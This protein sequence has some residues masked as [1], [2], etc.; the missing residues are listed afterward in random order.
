MSESISDL[1]AKRAEVVDKWNALL[2]DEQGNVKDVSENEESEANQYEKQVQELD[3]KIA[4]AEKAQQAKAAAAQ[5]VTSPGTVPA[6]AIQHDQ[7]KGQK[8]ARA[9]RCIARGALERRSAEDVA[10]EIYGDNAYPINRAVKALESGQIDGGSGA[11]AAGGFL[12]EEDF[13]AELIELLRNQ[14]SVMAMNPRT[15]PMPN[16]NLTIPGFDTGSAAS[17]TGENANISTT[18]PT[19]REVT[20]SAKK[21]AAIVPVSNDLIRF[22]SVDSDQAIRDDLVQAMALRMDLAFLRG[23]G[24]SN[25]PTGLLN[26]AQGANKFNA[27]DVSGTSDLSQKVQDIK[28]DLG[29]AELRLLNNNIPMTRPGWIMAPR[30]A[31]FLM[32]LITEQGAKAFPEMENGQL[33]GRPYR[34]SNQVP[35][36]LGSSPANESEIYLAD[37]AH[38]VVGEAS[39]MEV[40]ASETAAYHD[41]SNVQAAFS[42]D[43]TVMRAIARHDINLRH[44]AS[45]AVI[46]AVKWG[47]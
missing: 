6:Q 34:V 21:L 14:S 18:E 27:T 15:L 41:G 32:D 7:F 37:F 24:S 42:K 16:G 19:F 36:N 33:R 31:V 11:D 8:F 13:R 39:Q 25:T 30:T 29:K 35:I 20:L 17:Y 43:Q 26:L 10:K 38:V 1:R 9:V 46:Q 22:A 5:P 40:T 47:A 23:D 45:V 44:D 2:F 12:V 4:R 3:A 28:N